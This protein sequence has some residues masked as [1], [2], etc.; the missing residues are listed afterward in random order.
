MAAT[1]YI[2]L[3]AYIDRNRTTINLKTMTILMLQVSDFGEA[4]DWAK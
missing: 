2:E 3:P 4:R 1:S